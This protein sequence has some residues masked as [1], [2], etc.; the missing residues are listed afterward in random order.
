MKNIT[1][2]FAIAILSIISANDLFGQND[3][4]FLII[5][6]YESTDKTYNKIIVTENG[7]K[8]EE[9]PLIAFYYKNQEENQITINNALDKYLN[10]GYILNNVTKGTITN[11]SVMSTTYLFEKK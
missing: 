7:K 10:N 5:N 11:Y 4:G 6:V 2:T 9:I 1:L 8:I 3:K